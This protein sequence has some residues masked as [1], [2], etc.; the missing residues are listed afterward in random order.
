MPR[1]NGL[2]YGVSGLKQ[3]TAAEIADGVVAGNIALALRVMAHHVAER[4]VKCRFPASWWWVG[5]T[6]ANI[7]LVQNASDSHAALLQAS[8]LISAK[9]VGIQHDSSGVDIAKSL[10]RVMQVDP[11]AKAD[12]TRLIAEFHVVS[13]MDALKQSPLD[14]TG[15]AG[16]KENMKRFLHLK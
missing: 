4:A 2:E 9:R 10:K 16:G 13:A 5:I 11:A 6:A 1:N 14:G 8:L 12:A 3:P 15:T 7:L